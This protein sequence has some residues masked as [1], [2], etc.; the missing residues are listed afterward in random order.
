[1]SERPGRRSIR[2]EG[3]DDASS[4]SYFVT[5]CAH[6][7]HLLFEDDRVAS[8][9]ESAWNEI[10]TH[11]R[12]VSLDAFV[13]MPNHIHGI[14]VIEQDARF[15]G[16]GYISPLRTTAASAQARSLG[17]IIGTFKAAV[18]RNLRGQDLWGDEPFWQRNYY[19]RVIRDDDELTRIREYI[20]NNPATWQHD[21]D[22]P[23]QIK[24]PEYDN[25][26][27]WLELAKDRWTLRQNISSNSP[28][29]PVVGFSRAVRV[30]N[31]VYVSGTAPWGPDG[32]VIPGDAYQQAK[33]CIANIEAAL[34][35]G[36]ASLKDVV[37]TRI[38][39][40]DMDQQAGVSLA[41]REAFGSIMPAATL[42]EVSRLATP[43]MLVEL[44]ADA[45]IDG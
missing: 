36:G 11:F 29:E 43:E 44:E 17:V 30:G 19:E 28:F 41:H 37:R 35:K 12:D 34:V 40:V 23:A 18:T 8:V 27:S 24:N 32:K 14:V 15:V 33:Q 10:P 38:Y 42:V 2:L 4:G 13:V 9:I 7:R 6:Q 21:A 5:I 16:A 22:N 39:V 20:A 26:W 3:W 1:M 31:N 25:A 45:V